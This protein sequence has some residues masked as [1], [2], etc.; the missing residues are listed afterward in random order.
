MSDFVDSSSGVSESAQGSASSADSSASVAPAESANSNPSVPAET[1][2]TSDSTLL[3]TQPIVQE[4]AATAPP[5]EAELPVYD[6]I[7]PQSLADEK[8]RN[9]FIAMRQ[10]LKDTETFKTQHEPVVAWI[11]ERGGFEPIK[12]DVELVD[13]LYATD[14][15]ERNQFY[16][17]LYEQ[18][19]AA[20]TRLVDDFATVPKV[21][22]KVLEQLGVTPENL[23]QFQKWMESGAWK[24]G[25]PEAPAEALVNNDTLR[26][27]QHPAL[28]QLYK[29]LP[30]WKRNIADG[31]Y[32]NDLNEY[33]AEQ[34]QTHEQAKAET[35]KVQAE[36]AAKIE[37]AKAQVAQQKERVYQ[38]AWSMVENA[39]KEIFPDASDAESVD[40]VM[41]TAK[42]K[43]YETPEGAALWNEL[44]RHIEDGDRREVEKKLP[45]M[46]SKAK[47]IAQER[48]K[49]L[50]GQASKARQLD[51]IMRAAE[52]GSPQDVMATLQRLRG[53]QAVTRPGTQPTGNQQKGPPP[54]EAGRYERANVLSYWPGN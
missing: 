43:L 32:G 11:D 2:G 33:L 22:E 41:S 36:N 25:E 30:Q 21:Q 13:R 52:S 3:G 42:A 9:A 4:G 14:P 46:I 23:G 29:E 8:A 10:G 54:K 37:A 24:E 12:A 27:I 26:E 18:S 6:Q 40:F 49:W 51:E 47:V 1:S 50:N 5:P 7:D 16:T 20:Y 38:N 17:S 19:P 35:A 39:V 48:A 44:E 28:Q 53:S 34:Y 45:L 31:L 15:Q